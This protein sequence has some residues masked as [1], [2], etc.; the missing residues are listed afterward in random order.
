MPKAGK[1]GIVAGK[2]NAAILQIL[3]RGETL[4][5]DVDLEQLSQKTDGYSGS[6][7][8][9]ELPSYSAD[10]DLCVSAAL[11]A[12]KDQ[13]EVPWKKS[14][15]NTPDV[16][17]AQRPSDDSTRERQLLFAPA[18]VSQ[19]KPVKVSPI[20]ASGSTTVFCQVNVSEPESL[21]SS[22]LQD[23]GEVDEL[24][25]SSAQSPSSEASEGEANTTTIENGFAPEVPRRV[26]FAKHFKSALS[27]IRPSSTEEG[28]LPELRKVCPDLTKCANVSGQSSLEKAG[29]YVARRRALER[30][31]AL[32]MRR[33]RAGMGGSRNEPLFSLPTGALGVVDGK[34]QERR[35][36]RRP[37]GFQ[38]LLSGC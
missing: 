30:A 34:S 37:A 24:D 17:A 13:V 38:R 36:A 29:H 2:A 8:K 18:T 31:S 19:P 5:D 27:E 4:A 11:A 22:I 1:V 28:S 9:R 32:V 16:M 35:C 26:L 7:L 15:G 3:L 14:L 21:Q 23:D 10:P 20:E 25:S 6:D 12:V 33:R